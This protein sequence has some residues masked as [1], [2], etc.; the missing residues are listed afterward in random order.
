VRAKTLVIL[1]ALLAGAFLLPA[2]SLPSPAHAESIE[3]VISGAV[4]GGGGYDG[5]APAAG[6]G[7][8]ANNLGEMFNTAHQSNIKGLVKLVLGLSFLGG[9]FL[10]YGG[11][12]KLKEAGD[13]GG[14]QVKFSDGLLRLAAGSFLVALVST[15]FVGLETL[16]SGRG[17]WDFG[18]AD[19]AGAVGGIDVD[20]ASG[21]QGFLKMAGNFAINAAG[22]L[23]TL[24]MAVAVLI[25][26]VLVSSALFGMSK[27][28]SPQAR[29]GFGGLAMKMAV[30]I[31]LTNTFWIIDVASMSFGLTDLT[32]SNLTA[33][34]SKAD[35]SLLAYQSALADKN[36]TGQFKHLMGLAFLGLVPFGLIAFVRGMLMVK[37]SVEGNRQVSMG[38]GFTHII[39]GVMLV[40]GHAS[41]C[42]V[43][44]TLS[45]GAP[46]C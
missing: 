42:A 13:S 14:S 27:L 15:V 41:S 12:V 30:G 6:T 35:G 17:V 28:G 39:G 9:L 44:N 1:I 7:A 37:D 3:D 25:G 18:K 26:I 8:A 11:L 20:G 5:S 32:E 31:C 4:G 24:V 19:A 46:W 22:P 36:V 2:L 34:S 45:G 40:N 23:S 21:T 38:A 16:G 43:M 10:M 33:I 29:E